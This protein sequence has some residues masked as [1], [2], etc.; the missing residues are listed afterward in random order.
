MKW[1]LVA[2][3]LGA[4]AVAAGAFE[5]HSLR[6][7]VVRSWPMPGAQPPTISYYTLP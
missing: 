2:S 7:R 4:L 3:V 5:A 1:V 6:Y